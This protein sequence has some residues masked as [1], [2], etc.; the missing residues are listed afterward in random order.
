M[1]AYNRGLRLLPANDAGYSGKPYHNFTEEYQIS[2]HLM[3]I[4]YLII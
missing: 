4:A 2:M 3:I 1:T